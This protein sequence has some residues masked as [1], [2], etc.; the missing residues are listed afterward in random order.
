MPTDMTQMNKEKQL[1]PSHINCRRCN[2]QHPRISK[3]YKDFPG[4]S[5]SVYW[6]R[7]DDGKETKIWLGY[8]CDEGYQYDKG[9]QDGIIKKLLKYLR[10]LLDG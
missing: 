10:S 7:L 8:E 4:E 9:Y 6:A 3:D 2:Q 1:H 5:R